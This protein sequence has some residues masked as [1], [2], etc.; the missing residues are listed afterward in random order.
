MRFDKYTIKAQ[1]AVVRAQELAR[2]RDHSEVTALHLLAAL[3][4]EEEGVVKPMLQKLGASSERIG[5]IVRTELD[6]L[7][8]ATGTQTNLARSL[9]QGAQHVPVTRHLG[10]QPDPAVMA[11]ADPG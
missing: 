3:L 2:E 8:R 6:R 10:G 5:S 7:P 1:E 11:L 9:Q 4:E